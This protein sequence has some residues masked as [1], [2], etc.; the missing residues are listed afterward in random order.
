MCALAVSENG[1]A[2]SDVP[3]TILTGAEGYKICL[4]AVRNDVSG[5][6]LTVVP[7][8]YLKGDRGRR[9][10][11]EAVSYN[12]YA[13]RFVPKRL[14]SK[15]LVKS[16]FNHQAPTRRKASNSSQSL[17]MGLDACHWP[18]LLSFI[19]QKFLTE[20]LVERAVKLR[21]SELRDAP[22]ELISKDICLWAI[23]QDPM[24]LKYI[25]N[26]DNSILEYALQKKPAH[27]HGCSEMAFN[28]R[29][30]PNGAG[31]RSRNTHQLISSPYHR[32]VADRR[33]DRIGI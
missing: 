25:R 8:E 22:D 16:A 12:G 13:I 29:A 1:E 19:P 33:I 28:I 18:S 4:I 27:N 26:P 10:C 17:E 32:T 3:A 30:V 5:R 15:T 14:L 20:E 31:A 2:L 23:D 7:S 6:A 21:P 9:L 11:M 24:N